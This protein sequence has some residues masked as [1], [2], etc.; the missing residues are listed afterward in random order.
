VGVVTAQVRPAQLDI[1]GG[2]YYVGVRLDTSQ[3]NGTETVQTVLHQC[4]GR[5]GQ[6]TPPA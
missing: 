2:F 1:A 5:F 3:G 4:R 6:A